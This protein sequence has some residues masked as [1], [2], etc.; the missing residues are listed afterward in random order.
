MKRVLIIAYH[1][2][3]RPGVASNR[4]GGLAKHLPDYGWES[5]I[6]TTPLHEGKWAPY[7]KVIETNYISISDKIKNIFGLKSGIG[8]QHQLGIEQPERN[9]F[10]KWC[11]EKFKEI[12]DYPDEFR[13]WTKTAVKEG[14]K[15][16][17]EEKIDAIVSSSSPASTHLIASQLSQK[18]QIPWIAD[19]RDL[20]T[21]NHCYKYSSLRLFF[22]RALECNTLKKASALVTVS[23]PLV[24]KLLKMHNKSEVY[25]ITNTF[26]PEEFRVEDH[27]PKK[28]YITYTGQIYNKKQD[29]RILLEVIKELLENGCID[30]QK[31]ELRF[32]G[33]HNYMLQ[34]QIV[35]IGL[36]QNVFQYGIIKREL[37][38]EKQRESSV[39]LL[40]NWNDPNESGVYTGKVF[41]Y[42]AA[43]RN[44]LSIG[45]PGGVVGS[46][47]KIT[48]TGVHINNKIKLREILMKW[49]LEF[50]KYGEIQYS[51]VEKN[52]MK[53]THQNLARQYAKVLDNY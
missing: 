30:N 28:F 46:L 16:I 35:G 42:L 26:D 5:I 36:T 17:K 40:L 47:L 38:L 14:K 3:P 18:Q 2:P 33:P 10:F 27:K 9:K 32:Y 8:L 53:Y 1:Y 37:A 49:Y 11:I 21:Q 50:E 4:I 52:V 6:L 19:L 48:N 34:K 23:E 39:L 13:T 15:L 44:I 7:A 41:E 43:R 31:V 45:G 24:E 29:P 20:W 25:C 12:I 51:P 22:E